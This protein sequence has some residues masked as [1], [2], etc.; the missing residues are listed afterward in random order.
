MFRVGFGN[1]VLNYD[2]IAKMG[3]YSASEMR[4]LG[5]AIA[6]DIRAA[7]K[8]TRSRRK[9]AGMRSAGRSKNSL[10]YGPISASSKTKYVSKTKRTRN[11]GKWRAMVVR[12]GVQLPYYGHFVNRG[13]QHARGGFRVA[14]TYFVDD[15]I[16]RRAVR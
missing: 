9:Q 6:R 13:F 12:A 2:E 10:A 16:R 7:S 3:E 14:G 5:G 11:N 1:N 4:K 8:V 15:T